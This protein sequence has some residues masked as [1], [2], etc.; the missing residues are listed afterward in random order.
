VTR[1]ALRQLW[2]DTDGLAA[3]MIAILGAGLIGVAGVALD[4]GLYYAGQR[5][6]QAMTEAAALSA[7]IDPANARQRAQAFLERNGYP[8]SVLQSVTVGRYCP[9]VTLAAT[10]RFYSGATPSGASCPGNGDANAVQIQTSL[11]SK[12]YLTNLLG[13][14]SVTPRLSG[15]ATAARIDEAGVEMTSGVLMVDAGLLGVVNTVLSRLTGLNILLSVNALQSLLASHVDAG[16]MFDALATRIGLAEPA[17]Y[18]DLMNRTVSVGDLLGACASSMQQSGGDATAIATLQNLSTAIGGRV[19]VPLSKLFQ[20]GVWSKMPVGHA[21]AQTSLRAGLNAYQLLVYALEVNGGSLLG[22]NLNVAGITAGVNAMASGPV[23]RAR[24]GFGPAGQ[25]AVS[26]AAVRLQVGLTVP[27]PTSLLSG[28]GLGRTDSGAGTGLLNV[29]L[30]IDIGEG[31]AGIAGITCAQEAAS[32]ADVQVNGSAGLLG[33]YIGTAPSDVMTQPFRA[34][35]GTDIT[36]APLLSLGLLGVTVANVTIKA[37]AG[38]VTGGTQTLDFL[39]P[40]AGGAYTIGHVPSGGTPALVGGQAQLARTL[41][42]LTIDTR[43]NVLPPLVSLGT[44]SLVSSLGG[45]VGSLVGGLGVDTLVTDLLTA[46]GV[47]A[48]NAS[49]WVTGVRCG[50]P[51]LV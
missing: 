38:P 8:A 3:P 14:V 44:G 39:Q 1:R 43:V 17:T 27:S 13:S 34:I 40:A 16:L 32:D 18:S 31:S 46:L 20:L 41:S 42:G 21:G 12:R 48:G 45:T 49:V 37:A 19:Q 4:V 33:V 5:N 50:V 25:I 35:S 6:L 11:A 7:A 10:A 36:P 15:T 24:F 2:S 9:D 26:T 23:A 22:V 28:L 29:P 30:L 47:S 51:V